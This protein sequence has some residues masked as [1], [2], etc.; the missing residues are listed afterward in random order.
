MTRAFSLRNYRPLRIGRLE[1]RISSLFCRDPKVPPPNRNRHAPFGTPQRQIAER[2]PST[3]PTSQ[4]MHP[5]KIDGRNLDAPHAAEPP[6][7]GIGRRLDKFDA[8]LS[9]IR[10]KASHVVHPFSIPP[11]MDEQL[12]HL[13]RIAPCAAHEENRFILGEQFAK[14]R[15]RF[16]IRRRCRSDRAVFGPFDRPCCRTL[17]SPRHRQRRGQQRPWHRAPRP[18]PP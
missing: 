13:P 14:Q 9:R 10:P 4:G 8:V 11:E 2:A 5:R 16:S 15:L 18:G 6:V 7:I 17:V 1:R 12:P 3:H